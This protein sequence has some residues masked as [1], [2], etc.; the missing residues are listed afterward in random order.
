[1][2]RDEAL[3]LVR[4]YVKNEGL[5]RHMLAV[6]AA[7]AFYAEKF[8]QD[9]EKW[10]VTALLHDFDWK[11]TPPSTSTRRPASQFCGNAACRMRS[12]APSSATPITC[13][14]AAT[15]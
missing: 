9:V 6:E 4:E 2:T 7:M 10:R 8:H 13:T 11:S 1:M 3:A 12:S 15:A 5:V 14:S